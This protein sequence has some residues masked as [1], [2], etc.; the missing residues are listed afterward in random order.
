MHSEGQTEYDAYLTHLRVTADHGVRIARV[1]LETARIEL[2]L[3]MCTIED[4][5]RIERDLATKEA[6]LSQLL[7]LQVNGHVIAWKEGR[8]RV[9]MRRAETASRVALAERVQHNVCA[10]A[11]A[12]RQFRTMMSLYDRHERELQREKMF[13]LGVVR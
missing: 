7:G 13:Q 4:V 3:N 8:V 9:A 6:E 11:A 10:L 1:Q 2:T 12:R 5:E